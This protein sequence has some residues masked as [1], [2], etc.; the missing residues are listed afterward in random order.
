MHFRNYD[1]E[2]VL[3]GGGEEP[4]RLGGDV[5]GVQGQV[6]WPLQQQKKFGLRCP[7][8]DRHRATGQDHVN[9][10][11]RGRRGTRRLGQQTGLPVFLH[12]RL[13]WTW[14]RV[15]IPVLVLQ[16]RRR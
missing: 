1:G 2:D 12:Q 9:R 11:P 5:R 8:G 10:Q 16:K 3:L 15:E 13:R 4:G 7:K 6:G 14:E